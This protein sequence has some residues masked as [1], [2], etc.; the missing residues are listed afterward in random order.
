MPTEKH[1]IINNG[2]VEMKMLHNLL[3]ENIQI[4][5]LPATEIYAYYLQNKKIDIKSLKL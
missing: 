5:L 4:R 2:Y 3:L 1:E